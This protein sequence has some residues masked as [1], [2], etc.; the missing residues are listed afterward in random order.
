MSTPAGPPPVNEPTNAGGSAGDN[1]GGPMVNID[2]LEV[3]QTLYRAIK[4]S[5]EDA[6]AAQDPR[7]VRELAQAALAFSQAAVIL[8]P[9]LVAPQGVPADALHPPQPTPRPQ[10]PQDR[11]QKP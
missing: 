5:A 6:A 9:S 1:T 4:R 2:R 11:S 3:E 10:I 7:E 8:D